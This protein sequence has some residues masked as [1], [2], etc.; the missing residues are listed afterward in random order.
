[1]LDD[2]LAPHLVAIRLLRLLRGLLGQFF[3]R[4]LRRFR[5]DSL[6]YRY[7]GVFLLRLRLLLFR[8]SLCRH[9]LCRYLRGFRRLLRCRLCCGSLC[10]YLWLLRRLLYGL[11][12]FLLRLGLLGLRRLLRNLVLVLVEIVC[13][14]CRGLGPFQDGSLCRRTAGLLLRR[15]LCLLRSLG[16]SLCRYLHCFRNSLLL[17]CR[18]LLF[19][20]KH[21][22]RLRFLRYGFCLCGRLRCRFLGCSFCLCGRLRCRFL[23]WSL[24]LCCGL[25]RRFLFRRCC[26]LLSRSF[27]RCIFRGRFCYRLG[28]C[29]LCLRRLCRRSFLRRSGRCF[30]VGLRAVQLVDN[31]V[32]HRLRLVLL[33]GQL[34]DIIPKFCRGTAVNRRRSDAGLCLLTGLLRV[35][36]RLAS[37][38]GGKV[39]HIGLR[40]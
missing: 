7:L 30:R 39:C 35:R 5:R 19:L 33:T 29:G 34:A 31:I 40:R 16:G 26:L 15:L 20:R 22:L 10:C 25:L 2:N 36:Y 9:G 4:L 1:M 23:G 24:C 13:R 32:F 12:R 37:R 17:F 27:R 8:S 3:R 21:I 28:R 11:R 38:C 18:S 6:C 14:F